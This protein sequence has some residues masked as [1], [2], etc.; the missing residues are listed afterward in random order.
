MIWSV[1]TYLI[2]FLTMLQ[3]LS[4][5][6]AVLFDLDGVLVEMVNTHFLA[7]NKALS[8]F[9][10]GMTEEEHMKNYNGLP[11]RIK[12][13][14]MVDL[15]KA[16]HPM[17]LSLKARYTKE[18][19][20]D[21]CKPSYDKIMML[22]GLKKEGFKLACC[23][24]AIKESVVEMLKHSELLDF[25][26]VVIGNDEGFKPKPDPAIYIGA[27][28]KLDVK[29]SECL[30]VED[31]PVGVEAAQLSGGRV[32]IVKNPKDVNYSLFQSL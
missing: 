11:T 5:Y 16:L 12:L 19:V 21:V 31:S 24:N 22:H 26:D 20:R 9:G 6:R 14:K 10:F 25:F 15:P 32:V 29:P 18:M 30:I 1:L 7:F 13:E 2:S 4:K 3:N 27:M 28:L 17:I 23:S 8:L